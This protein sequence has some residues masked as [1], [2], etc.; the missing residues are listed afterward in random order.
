[1]GPWQR[2]A[3]HTSEQNEGSLAPVGAHSRKGTLFGHVNSPGLLEAT[4]KPA[5]IR[6]A[7]MP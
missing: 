2:A 3:R 6:T 1:M 5:A 4:A 7:S